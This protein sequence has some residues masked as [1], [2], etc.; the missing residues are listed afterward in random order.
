[1]RTSAPGSGIPLRQMDTVDQ[2]AEKSPG[3]PTVTF[4]QRAAVGFVWMALQ[5]VVS[6]FVTVGGQVVLAWLLTDADFGVIA[7]AFTAAAFPGQIN[8]IG[9]KEVLVRR[10]KRYHLW[11]SSA[12][13]MALGFGVVSAI[14]IA[15]I[16]WPAA[17]VFRTPQLIGLLLIMAMTA[18]IELLSQVL[19]IKLQIDLRF[20][21]FAF[22]A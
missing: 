17:V 21:A 9:L 22:L 1:M 14:L 3:M 12:H 10:F 11:A 8:Q 16:A 2:P 18:P 7:L 20:R 13:W 4:G 5:T 6:K 19:V 15:A